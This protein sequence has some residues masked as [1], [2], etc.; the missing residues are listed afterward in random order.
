M[1]K[2]KSF[3]D[4]IDEKY[5]DMPKPLRKGKYFF[6]FC[7][8]VWPVIEFCV[9]YIGINFQSLMMAFQIKIGTE[10]VWSMDNF[11]RIFNAVGTDAQELLVAMKNT[12]LFFIQDTFI[13]VPVTFCITFYFYRERFATPVL[14][15]IVFLPSI[16]PV[17][18]TITIF[19]RLIGYHGI[20]NNILDLLNAERIPDYFSDPDSAIWITLFYCFWAGLSANILYFQGAMHRI[21]EEVL[22]AARID[23]CSARQ[24]MIKITLPLVFNTFSIVMLL[25]V[26]ALFTV[27][28]PILLLTGGYNDTQTISFWIYDQTVSNSLTLPAAAGVMFTILTIPLVIVSRLIINKLDTK[29]EY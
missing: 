9:F 5:A 4:K 29:V 1:N 28:G 11:V 17:M 12:G 22:E 2:I 3:F 16:L 23:G 15:V 13:L 25:K 10:Y 20:V 7:M 19:K 26:S 6:I 14:R 27:S 8:A 21:P 18:L 24:E